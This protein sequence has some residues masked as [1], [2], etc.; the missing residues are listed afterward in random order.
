MLEVALAWFVCVQNNALHLP[1]TT[2]TGPALVTSSDW[3]ARMD[4]G[5]K[6]SSERDPLG[7]LA[8]NGRAWSCWKG[9]FPRASCY[10]TSRQLIAALPSICRLPPGRYR[11]WQQG[12]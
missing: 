1:E 3:R 2:R 5:A 8:C 6:K 11:R 4:C 7:N 9:S 12:N 10:L